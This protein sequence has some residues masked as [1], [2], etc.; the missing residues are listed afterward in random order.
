MSQQN[1]CQM[2]AI[3]FLFLQSTNCAAVDRQQNHKK[4]ASELLQA[5]VNSHKRKLEND[6]FF[7]VAIPHAESR[8]AIIF[9]DAQ[10]DLKDQ[11]DEKQNR[12]EKSV[13]RKT[14]RAPNLLITGILFLL[15]A[16][17][18][19]ISIVAG[20]WFF[21]IHLKALETKRFCPVEEG[22]PSEQEEQQK[23][24]YLATFIPEQ[25]MTR[26]W[27]INKSLK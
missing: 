23:R 15:C 13:S 8:S 21:S 7:K 9:S 17:V 24:P 4:T 5:R 10:T 19:T 27:S 26:R 6:P 16:A 14:G 20:R 22:E 11:M 25:S 12:K 3:A 2:V 1:Y 18:L